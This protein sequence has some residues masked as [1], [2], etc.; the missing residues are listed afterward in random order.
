MLPPP[1]QIL[2]INLTWIKL[3]SLSVTIPHIL[4]F[5]RKLLL[6]IPKVLKLTL[7]IVK[8][9]PT[10][11]KVIL[12][13]YYEF[14]TIYYI[15]HIRKLFTF[16]RK[17]S[18]SHSFKRSVLWHFIGNSRNLILSTPIRINN[19]VWKP[20]HLPYALYHDN[21]FGLIT[22]RYC[23]ISTSCIQTIRYDSL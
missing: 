12:R 10:F 16:P 7:T 17:I 4:K 8:N 5:T 13:K 15:K 22:Q 21:F 20:Y 2:K 9:I 23:Y 3:N 11:L 14:F 19:C 1:S 18:N 6:T